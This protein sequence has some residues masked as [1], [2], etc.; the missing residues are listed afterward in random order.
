MHIGRFIIVLSAFFPLFVL[1]A[2]AMAQKT[3]CWRDITSLPV[4]GADE[5]LSNMLVAGKKSLCASE[6]PKIKFRLPQ[7]L[8]SVDSPLVKQIF[9]SPARLISFLAVST[10]YM[11]TIANSRFCAYRI[12]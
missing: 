4:S 5:S 3:C 11:Y 7:P 12:T 10:D 6:S 1:N 2:S 8:S 9:L